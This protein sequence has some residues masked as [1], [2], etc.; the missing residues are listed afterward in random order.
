MIRI[1]DDVVFNY[2]LELL[3]HLTAV[4]VD[5]TLHPNVDR[6]EDIAAEDYLG[7]DARQILI[8][9]DGER[10]V[11]Q[12]SLTAI[13]YLI[14]FVD[15]LE[16]WDLFQ[17]WVLQIRISSGEAVASEGPVHVKQEVVRKG[18]IL[19]HRKDNDAIQ[20]PSA[21]SYEFD[22]VHDDVVSDPLD[23]VIIAQIMRKKLS[24]LIH[25]CYIHGH[26]VDLEIIAILWEY[27]L[28]L[29]V[30]DTVGDACPFIWW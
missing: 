12:W 9:I 15:K 28:V 3:L 6:R 13:D 5:E 20:T 17:T 24:H 8:I 25:P 2:D 23:S 4:Y 11:H 29:Q 22:I 10:Q 1:L 26:I 27:Q 21:P 30:E 19:R 14:I 7:L 18:E 16:L